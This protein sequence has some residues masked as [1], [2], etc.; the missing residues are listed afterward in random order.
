MLMLAVQ[1]MQAILKDVQMREQAH[2]IQREVTR[3]MDDMG[4]FRERVLDL[5][6]HFGQANQDIEKILTSS[7]KIAQRGRKIETLEFEDGAQAPS[8][9]RPRFTGQTGGG[10]NGTAAARPCPVFSP[11]NSHFLPDDASSSPRACAPLIRGARRSAYLRASSIRIE[12]EDGVV[13]VVILV[14]RIDDGRSL[15]LRNAC[16]ASTSFRLLKRKA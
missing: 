1:T 6:R 10:A 2:L 9:R 11:A 15:S 12:E 3:L 8:N 5:Q 16:N 4:R 13:I 7:D 14:P